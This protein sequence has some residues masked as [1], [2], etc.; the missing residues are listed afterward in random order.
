MKTSADGA[1]LEAF[2]KF[3]TSGY[4]HKLFTEALY[5]EMMQSFGFIAHFD[6]GSFYLARFA[7]P[8]VRVYTYTAI[9]SPVDGQRA[10][11]TGIT[12]FVRENKLLNKAVAERD[13]E[14]EKKERAE[15][16]RLKAKYEK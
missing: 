8:D 1:V 5:K 16:K 3:V 14:I 4:K 12:A 7:T 10:L 13:A 2:K 15:L 9:V 6:R 11:A